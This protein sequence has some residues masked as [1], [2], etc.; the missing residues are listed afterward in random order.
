MADKITNFED[1]KKKSE[2]EPVENADP[3]KKEDVVSEQK[4]DKTPDR[5]PERKP[6]LSETT[7]INRIEI[8]DPY[9]FFTEEEREAYFRERQKAEKAQDQDTKGVTLP[10]NKESEKPIRQETKKVTAQTA[11]VDKEPEKPIRQR[12]PRREEYYEDDVREEYE[13]DDI[14][15][16]EYYYP[17][18]DRYDDYRED[19][20]G[21]YE[22]RYDDDYEDDYDESDDKLMRMVVR[23]A[24]VLTGIIILGIVAF[25]VKSLVFDK[26][27]NEDEESNEPGTEVVVDPSEQQ[28]QGFEIPEG[29]TQTDDTVTVINND[30]NLRNKPKSV[31]GS[32]V[33]AVAKV[34]TQLKRVALSNDGYWAIVEYDGQYLYASTNYLSTP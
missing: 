5:K 8:E 20:D 12:R 28:P 2:T 3:I 31:E 17:E 23:I 6:D 19:Y 10:K 29:Y 15:D 16:D 1:Y 30:L 4:P 14:R 24:S 18:D 34:G 33:M 25:S 27:H 22:D 9:N 7:I 11:R 21:E 13:E 26:L 32:E